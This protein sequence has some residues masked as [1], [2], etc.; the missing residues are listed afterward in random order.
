MTV[1]N[2]QQNN[3]LYQKYHAL[4]LEIL[5]FP[6]AQY[7]NQEPGANTEILDCLE[8]VRPGGGYIPLF[9]L[10]QKSNVNGELA[11][12]IYRWLKNQCGAP[13]PN[14]TPNGATF[15]SWTPVMTNDI[16]WNFEKF[17][18]DRTG[19]PFKRY[20]PHTSPLALS[21]DIEFL[22]ANGSGTLSP[23]RR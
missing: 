11:N 8:Y 3:Q 4:G 12:P 17:L 2:Y 14:L 13:S 16:T 20:S 21:D 18:L 7:N 15:V 6:C 10:F 19:T 23:G 1:T 22:L 9:P 5:A